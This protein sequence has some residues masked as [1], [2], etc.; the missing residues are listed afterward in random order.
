MSSGNPKKTRLRAAA[1]RAQVLE[2]ALPLFARF[3]FAGTGTRQISQ[4]AG[5]SEPIL[6]RHFESKAG[7]FIAA[8]ELVQARVVRGLSALTTRG[9]D[10]ATRLHAVAE[11][12]PELLQHFRTELR[13]L[14][15]ASQETDEPEVLEAAAACA[16]ALGEALADLFEAGA[17]RDG[18]NPRLAGFLLLQIGM[19][20][21]ILHP[22][23]LDMMESDAYR[24]AVVGTLLRGIRKP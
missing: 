22:L 13:V 2:H 10:T 11:G 24:A 12:L 21:S 23:N 3:G 8:L 20:A 7:L 17:L 6:Y 18:M 1:R 14:N 19:G 16:T 5:V 15:A 4:A 9:S